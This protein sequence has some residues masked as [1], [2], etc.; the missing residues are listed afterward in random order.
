MFTTGKSS[1]IYTMDINNYLQWIKSVTHL[2]STT[3]RTLLGEIRVKL[4][5]F[6]GAGQSGNSTCSVFLRG[7]GKSRVLWDLVA[8][9]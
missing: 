7:T 1:K 4:R 2:G 3:G 6:H 8:F 9:S 5:G